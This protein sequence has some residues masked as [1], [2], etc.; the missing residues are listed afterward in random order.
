MKFMGHAIHPMLI[1]FPLGLLAAVFGAID[2]WGIRSST[3][4][5][6]IGLWLGIV[7][8][9][10][11]LLFIGSWFLRYDVPGYAPSTSAT[12]LSCIA[13]GCA[14][15]SGW[16]GGELL[17]RLGVGVDS[18]AHLNAPNSLSGSPASEHAHDAE[19]ALP[20]PHSL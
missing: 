5:K 13:V 11:V 1:V 15:I 6:A 9:I 12:T 3:R 16:L 10:V 8:V 7:S 18:R 2:W 20:R 17:E 19:S 14:L 4:A